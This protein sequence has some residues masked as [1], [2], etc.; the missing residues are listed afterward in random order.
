MG[1]EIFAIKDVDEC[2]DLLI[3]DIAMCNMVNVQLLEYQ[4]VEKIIF[5]ELLTC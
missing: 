4:I 1:R 5:R 2:N 3:N